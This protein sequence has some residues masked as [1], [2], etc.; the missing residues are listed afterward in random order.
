[1][2]RVWTMVNPLRFLIAL[3]TFLGVLAFLIHFLLLSTD[4]YNWLEDGAK[5]A[6]EIAST[7]NFV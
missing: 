2:H 4:R 7:V 3:Y 6:A 1:M 5:K